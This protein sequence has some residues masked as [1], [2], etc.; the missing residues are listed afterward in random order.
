MMSFGTH[1]PLRDYLTK[2]KMH[3]KYDVTQYCIKLNCVLKCAKFCRPF[4]GYLVSVQRAN[5]SGRLDNDW[6]LGYF[7]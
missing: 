2:N 4:M 6:E 5:I 3:S 1:C 7:C